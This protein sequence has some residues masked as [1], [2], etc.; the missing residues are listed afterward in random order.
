MIAHHVFFTLHDGSAENVRKLLDACT[1]YLPGHDGIGYFAVGPRAPELD[2]EVNDRDFHVGLHVVFRDLAA[3][4]AYQIAPDH[5]KFVAEAKP[6]WKSVRVFDTVV[7]KS[8]VH[9]A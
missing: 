4:D 2:R 8:P 1:K 3:H 9:G 6:L 5:L 7:E